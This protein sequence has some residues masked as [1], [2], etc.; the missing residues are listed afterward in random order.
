MR[1]ER[2]LL[3]QAVSYT[4]DEDNETDNGVGYVELDGNFTFIRTPCLNRNVLS[5]E[6]D[7][8][9]CGL[10]SLRA[11]SGLNGLNK[12]ANPGDWP[13]HVALF[14]DNIHLCD[15]TLVSEDWVLTTASCFQG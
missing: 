2:L 10:Q 11:Q 9:K 8:L 5:V 14:K 15:G 7:N 4:I 3:F 1:T 12:M 13:W 6:C